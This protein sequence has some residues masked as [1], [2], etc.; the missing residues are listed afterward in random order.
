MITVTF[1]IS[2]SIGYDIVSKAVQTF[3]TALHQNK[4]VRFTGIQHAFQVCV[5]TATVNENPTDQA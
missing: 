2:V 5:P 3:E 4:N 1:Y